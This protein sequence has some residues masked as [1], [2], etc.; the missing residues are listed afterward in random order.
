MDEYTAN[1]TLDEIVARLRAIDTCTITAHSKPDGDAWGSVTALAQTLRK[2]GKNVDA[3]LMPPV[4]DNLRQL[5]SRGGTRVWNPGD[6]LP[7]VDL[8]L[9]LDTGAWSQLEPIRSQLEPRLDRTL[10]V[11][12]HI[13]GDVPAA[14]RLIDGTAA[15]AC[16]VVAD[17]IDALADGEGFD[18]L[19]EPI[20]R[21]ALFVGIASDTG[22]FRFS[23]T[24]PR[25]HALAG[26]LIAAGVDHAALY[27]ALEQAERPEKL[28]LMIRCLDSLQL[29]AA[30]QVAVMVVRA[31]DFQATGAQLGDTERFVDLPQIVATVRVV[32][33]VTQPPTAG[34]ALR[35]SFRSKPGP[36]AVNVADLAGR[37]GGGG[38]ARAA[39]AKVGGE[40]LESLLPRLV[41]ACVASLDTV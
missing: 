32:V 13:S 22:W 1:Q 2:L 18:P 6:T 9:V 29:H 19:H 10:I 27:A 3:F 16:E 35:L 31:E 41:T 5:D 26:R 40:T 14:F 30:D 15:A 20:V 21:E 37:F 17:L 25:T 39:G 33:L 8:H 12:H 24:S 28:K 34:E 4:P 11:D 23:N 36:D 38:H 7:E